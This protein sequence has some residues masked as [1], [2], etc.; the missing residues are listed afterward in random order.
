MYTDGRRPFCMRH[1]SG[2]SGD[3]GCQSRSRCVRARER[4]ASPQTTIWNRVRTAALPFVN[5][6]HCSPGSTSE[7]NYGARTR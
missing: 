7:R 3:Y 1:G 6:P 2:W 4:S 5:F